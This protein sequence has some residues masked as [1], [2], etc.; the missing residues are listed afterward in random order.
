M[1]KLSFLKI[2]DI[3]LKLNNENNSNGNFLYST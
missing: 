1:L 2:V 3:D